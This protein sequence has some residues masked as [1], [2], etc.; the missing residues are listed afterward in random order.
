M[1]RRYSGSA[2]VGLWSWG[3]ELEQRRTRNVGNLDGVLVRVVLDDHLLQVEEGL[4]VAHLAGD[5][6]MQAMCEIPA[7]RPT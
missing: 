2:P 3:A 4:L 5:G 6:V 1:R 7:Q